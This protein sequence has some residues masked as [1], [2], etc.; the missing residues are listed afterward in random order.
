[1]VRTADRQ[2][3]CQPAGQRRRRNRRPVIAALS[4]LMVILLSTVGMQGTTVAHAD[5]DTPSSWSIPQY[6]LTANVDR[7]G[8]ARVTVDMAFDFSNDRGRGPYLTFVKRQQLTDDP[9]HWRMIDYSGFSASSPSGANSALRITDKDAAVQLRIGTQGLTYSGVQRYR[10]SF[11]VHGLIA[12]RNSAS[13]LDEF[14][15]R[16]F[17]SFDVPIASA[18]VRIT[19]PAAVSRTA[20]SVSGGCQAVSSGST[21]EFTASDIPRRKALQV[22]AGFPAGTFSDQAVAR[23]DKRYHVGN[24][25]G[26]NPATGI[27]AVLA[28]LLA[29]WAALRARRRSRDEEFAGVAAGII[30]PGGEGPV[31]TR[32]RDPEVAVAFQPPRDVSP[33]EAGTLL[34]GSADTED[35]TAGLLDL[36]VRGHLTITPMNADRK[37]RTENWS[38]TRTPHSGDKL[39]DWERQ[40]LDMFFGRSSEV[41]TAELRGQH[42]NNTL[43]V[44]TGNL[45]TAVKAYGWYH[46]DPLTLR[47]RSLGAGLG[48]ALIGLLIAVAGAFVGWGLL[49]VPVLLIGVVMAVAG[50]MRSP[51]RTAKG[52]AVLDQVKGFRLYLTTAEADQIKF[53]EG[54]DVFSR[55]LPWATV[56]GVADRWVKIFQDLEARGVYHADYGWYGGNQ[57]AFNMAFAGG[58]ASSLND[59]TSA[60]SSS[61]QAASASSAS[62]SGSGF[63]GGGGFGGGGGGGW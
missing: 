38:F 60:M 7:D 53:E 57:M 24:T 47:L 14:N 23:L 4:C 50:L 48:V 26:L 31:Q 21:A 43:S 33:A 8:N 32:R 16:V 62:A 12:P 29:G 58:F 22:V 61:M 3:P 1:M 36:A 55:Y 19:G 5:D 49:G 9:D 11:T 56:F 37:G 27:G 39:R 35:A 42:D 45:N 13:G 63:S 54:I 10:V 34:D 17:D 44:T 46:T 25:F 28:A 2:S 41:T 20:C 30:P 15:W 52:T 59:M 51:G 6:D 40:Y 18:K